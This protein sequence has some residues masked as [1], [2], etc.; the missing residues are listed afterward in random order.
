MFLGGSLNR[1]Q[2]RAK[3]VLG[4]QALVL[5]QPLL[6]HASLAAEPRRQLLQLLLSR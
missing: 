5:T 4:H 2:V 3:V 1:S 6:P